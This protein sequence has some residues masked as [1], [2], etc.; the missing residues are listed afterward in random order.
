MSDSPIYE[1]SSPYE[2]VPVYSEPAAP[3]S[4]F[5]R[6][7]VGSL[8]AEY[9][10]TW[11]TWVNLFILI[12]VYPALTLFG[13]SESS[14]D[15]LENITQAMLMF[16]LIS[17]VIMQWGIFLINFVGAYLE[18]TGLRGLGLKPIRAIDFGWAISFLLA[19]GLIIAGVTWLLNVLGM[20]APGELQWL[21]P[22]ETSGKVVWV[23][24]SFTAGFCEEIAFRG[25]LMTRLRLIGRFNS[26]LVPTIISTVVFAACHTYQGFPNAVQVG[27]YGLLLSLL[28]IRTKRL[29]PCIIAHSL[30]DLL[31]IIVPNF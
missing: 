27:T 17:T 7:K 18:R 2:R 24:V 26:W 13:M 16:L 22:K 10:T 6:F 20:P 25:Y 31:A 15:L 11:L 1:E 29:W 8:N 23:F 14:T 30:Q 4:D 9:R 19:A 12:I 28:Y 21:I 3:A 5:D